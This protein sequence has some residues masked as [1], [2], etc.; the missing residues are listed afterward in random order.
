MQSAIF[1]YYHASWEGNIIDKLKKNMVSH[2][3]LAYVKNNNL[4][5]H[6]IQ[7]KTYFIQ[8]LEIF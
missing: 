4:K 7:K 6:F 5:T 8:N 1:V 2:P 3:I